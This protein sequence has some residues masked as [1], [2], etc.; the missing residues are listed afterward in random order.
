[1]R[2]NNLRFLRI[3]FCMHENTVPALLY[4]KLNFPLNIFDDFL[5]KLLHLFHFLSQK[6]FLRMLSLRSDG[7]ILSSNIQNSLCPR[8]LICINVS[9]WSPH[10]SVINWVKDIS[11]QISSFRAWC[12]FINLCLSIW[13]YIETREI[14]FLFLLNTIWA[15]ML[16]QLIKY[17]WL[18]SLHKLRIGRR[19]DAFK[20]T[21]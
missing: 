16:N 18:D 7:H 4:L 14:I 12:S 15:I 20:E 1:M 21:V 9:I 11:I 19:S 13:N 5:S 8:H 17:C 6:Q 3:W 10:C 2:M